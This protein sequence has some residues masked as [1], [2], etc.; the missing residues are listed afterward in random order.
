MIA[1]K[2]I[3]SLA[4]AFA[5]IVSAFAGNP[6]VATDKGTTLKYANY[7]KNGKVTGYTLNTV[8]E[9]SR[10]NGITGVEISV[11]I[12][13]KNGAP[14]K[15]SPEVTLVY[16]VSDRDVTLDMQA[17]ME[18]MLPAEAREEMKASGGA[19]IIEGDEIAYPLQFKIGDSFPDANLSMSIK[20]EGKTIK[21]TDMGFSDRKVIS[22]EAVSTDAGDFE[23]YKIT[24][25]TTAKTVLGMGQT[26]TTVT[27]YADGLGSVMSETYSKKGKLESTTKL[28]SITKP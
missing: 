10:S 24:E 6:F 26:G 12:L 8:K 18:G 3:L 16:R 2:A 17:M 9:V 19:I 25:T 22:R 20:M 13:D 14:K 5:A 28:I 1:R 7:D 15:N 23:C 4:A 11:A 21:V 27:Y